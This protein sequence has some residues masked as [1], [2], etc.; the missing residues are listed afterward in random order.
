MLLLLLRQNLQGVATSQILQPHYR[1]AGGLHVTEWVPVTPVYVQGVTQSYRHVGGLSVN[2]WDYV[3]PTGVATSIAPLVGNLAITGYAPTVAQTSAGSSYG[4]ASE[5]RTAGSVQLT[6]WFA[7]GLGA[8]PYNLLPT[9]AGIT[10][11]GY[12]PTVAQT[13]AGSSYGIASEYRTAGSVQLTSWLADGLGANPYNLLPATAGVTFTGY[14]PTVSQA[15]NNSV[16]PG[17]GSLAITGYSPVV[18]QA[19]AAT[20]VGMNVDY[21]GLGSLHE[22]A[23][24]YVHTTPYGIVTEYRGLGPVQTVNWFGDGVS[25]QLPN[26]LS[27]ATKALAITGYAPTVTQGAPTTVAPGVGPLAITGYA[28]TVT[29]AGSGV[30]HSPQ[31]A[32]RQW[33]IE[34][35]TEAF[36]KKEK[37]Q[38]SPDPGRKARARR[39]AK[40]EQQ[41]EQAV[42][43]AEQDMQQLTG[44]IQDA[45]AA[46]RFL[47][48]LRQIALE[49]D[50]TIT[51]FVTIGINYRNRAL[52][53]QREEDE[54]LL[55]SM[56]L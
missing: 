47:D 45:E 34:Y 42:S 41:V 17:N 39:R 21:R 19:A 5:Y 33:L 23:W 1:S 20:Q 30:S 9:T 40:L 14:A 36:N 49:S 44:S 3:V 6:S 12:A 55:L 28:P 10:F 37:P 26:N 38:E 7:D 13:S 16:S 8:N 2:G 52:Q 25:V 56:V 35:Y 29:Q 27:P 43:Q 4:I 50:K 31:G 11:T 53:R 51:D 22:N 32:T 24:N 15:S 54:L 18:S 48:G 46:Q